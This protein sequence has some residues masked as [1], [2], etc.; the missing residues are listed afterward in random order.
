M[1]KKK[2]KKNTRNNGTRTLASAKVVLSKSKNPAYA[3]FK[4]R[5]IL[6]SANYSDFLNWLR[7]NPYLYK[8]AFAQPFPDSVE[9]LRT[10][11]SSPPLSLENELRW[12]FSMLHPHLSK[13]DSFNNLREQMDDAFLAGNETQCFMLLD[14][15]QEVYGTSIWFLKKKVTFIQ[16]FQGL[17]R[18]KIF[19]ETIKSKRESISG[20]ITYIVHYISYRSEPSVTPNSF[21]SNYQALLS[22]LDADSNLVVY[23]R[24]HI[25]S[26][27][28]DTEDDLA[29]LLCFETAGS[30]IDAYEMLVNIIQLTIANNLKSI[31][32][33]I[34]SVI[35]KLIKEISDIRLARA[36]CLINTSGNID[37]LCL[38][39]NIG[40]PQLSF[41]DHLANSVPCFPI[42]G[43]NHIDS[44]SR[45]ISS[46]CRIIFAHSQE[47]KSLL[48]PQETYQSLQSILCGERNHN[49]SAA[50]LTRI[51]WALEGNCAAHFLHLIL[52]WAE[53]AYLD[54]SSQPSWF[55]HI[56]G[57]G[58]ITPL[59]FWWIK[60]PDVRVLYCA[61]FSD[62]LSPLSKWLIYEVMNEPNDHI[63]SEPD[64]E[65][66]KLW[67]KMHLCI[68]TN[69]LSPTL[70]L[71]EKLLESN[72][73]FFQH[74]A[75]RTVP[76]CLTKLDQQEKCIN[77]LAKH[78]ILNPETIFLLPIKEVIETLS[79]E[80][81]KQMAGILSF[82]IVTDLYVTISGSD[83]S[84][85]RSFVAE[86]FLSLN[87]MSRPS[88]LRYHSGKYN[89]PQLI[90]FLRT[91]CTESVMDTWII[92]ESSIE[93]AKERVA[94]CQL[95]TEIDPE[96]TEEYQA[97]IR[98]IMRKLALKRR[99]R[100]VEQSK[101]YVDTSS[102]KVVSRK[103]LLESFMRYM[104]FLKTGMSSEE[105]QILKNTRQRV[106]Q[107]DVDALLSGAF[108]RNEM[109]ELFESII[110][111]LRNEFVSSSQHGLDGYLSVRIR[112]GTLA[113][114][115]RGPLEAE[116][117]VTLQDS[118]SGKYKDNDYW[119]KTLQ[120]DDSSNEKEL[121]S[122]L[123]GFT[124]SYDDL[125]EKIK[126]SWLQIKK[127]PEDN[128]LVD[129]TLLRPEVDYLS[130][131]IRENMT[132]ESFLEYVFDYFFS[133]KLEPSLKNIREK[134]QANA[135]PHINDLLL[136]LQTTVEKALGSNKTWPLRS[137]IGKART[138]LQNVIDRITEWFRLAE[139]EMLR[140]P[141]SVEEAVNISVAS[142]QAAC[143]DFEANIC[144]PAN[145]DD[146]RIAGNL[147]SFVD[148]LFLVFENAVRHSQMAPKPVVNIDVSVENDV[149]HIKAY[150]E[151][152]KDVP[153]DEIIVKT[154][155]IQNC[156]ATNVFSESV[157]TEGG[158]GFYK[159]QKILHHDFCQNEAGRKPVLD[160]G[161]AENTVFYVNMAI[162]IRIGEQ[163]D[164]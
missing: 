140:E 32:P 20:F 56:V 13:L 69:K 110:V 132:F 54:V 75:L 161:I 45:I 82:A 151:L 63:Y 102:V 88:E 164:E 98:D 41:Y 40:K 57:L 144:T 115:L 19:A 35:K 139:A 6:N 27:P 70:E 34:A 29:G 50:H 47:K 21:L 15:I 97:E 111:Q 152:G 124:K 147:P 156:L 109:S 128:G 73:A 55:R 53:C 127:S 65:D 3:I 86:D 103:I 121:Q 46:V 4:A 136:T 12:C 77:F 39:R 67:R 133:E 138:Q 76:F 78:T 159:M 61:I 154:Q 100:E 123:S 148:L 30:M 143:P 125:I 7:L 130:T 155:A 90:Y 74:Q 163:E 22:S 80:S 119:P 72:N 134:L 91:I 145:L 52:D 33:L 120:I 1:G 108:P 141:F 157:A 105:K 68:R 25:L 96:K 71:A 160:F 28:P 150:N 114:Q 26:L 89:L 84:Y 17:E 38:K 113:G 36:L 137:A 51:A 158:S 2:N 16:H 48:I 8:R 24:Q 18:Q 95:L 112:H 131:G 142:I 23:L 101:I 59:E 66:Y 14:N 11:P 106:A 85:L 116:H 49:S 117:L 10:H 126:S 93:V 81:Q 122:A 118:K 83:L 153:M 79:I 60:D 58:Q 162:P 5:Q 135:K 62:K 64:P 129:F 99:L 37:N 107:G 43:E 104:S 31:Y 44:T 92:F 146:F 149:L 87:K 9:D 42:N 94:V